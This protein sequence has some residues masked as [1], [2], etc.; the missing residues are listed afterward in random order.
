MSRSLLL[1]LTILATAAL[2][3]PS[4]SAQN[5]FGD[6][7]A[8]R[9]NRLAG[10]ERITTAT[11]VSN[12]YATGRPEAVL[13]R[14]DDFAD[15]LAGTVLATAADGP[16]LLT[17]A[18][19]LTAETAEELTRTMEPGGTVFL[20]G[21]TAALSEQVEADVRALG[22]TAERV[23]GPTRYATAVEMAELATGGD[24]PFRIYIADGNTFA[25]A[26]IA[27]HTA[28]RDDL[29]TVVLTDGTTIPAETQAYLDANPDVE[30][31]A[32]G[33]VAASTDSADTSIVGA[34]QYET[35]V[36]AAE[37]LGTNDD[38]NR[39]A[40]A[41]GVD[42]PDAL[43]GGTHAAL[44]EQPL[45]LVDPTAL[46]DSVGDFLRENPPSTMTVYGGVNAIPTDLTRA[47]AGLRFPDGLNGNASVFVNNRAPVDAVAC[48][49]SRDSA[50]VL[51]TWSDGTLLLGADDTGAVTRMELRTADLAGNALRV[52][53]AER[54]ADDVATYTGFFAEGG[55]NEVTTAFNV[56]LGLCEADDSGD[57]RASVQINEEAAIPA[58]VCQ[59][60]DRDLVVTWFES[61][62]TVDL[63]DQ[64]QPLSMEIRAAGRDGTSLDIEPID[65]SAD[66]T[67]AY[68]ASFDPET[69][70]GI[71][72]VVLDYNVSHGFVRLTGPSH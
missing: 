24:T 16:L 1:I 29:A 45:L 21:G 30:T 5:P 56:N 14:A 70:E 15:S 47:A 8:L 53:Q 13:V 68:F 17:R 12:E 57:A 60:A 44:F 27:G 25:D 66:D 50:D 49:T 26:L 40:F 23:A 54:I 71:E 65:S 62:L 10:P 41:S 31:I 61:T 72:K 43:A 58:T 39:V 63:D 42:F 20:A 35:S 55:I 64:R 46:P 52:D 32:V 69:T 51:I 67:V 36:L 37:S 18:D 6:V 3:V 59:D 33:P 28:A 7:D 2:G 9:T 34:D 11:A 38:D 4:A 19:A 48:N 22:F